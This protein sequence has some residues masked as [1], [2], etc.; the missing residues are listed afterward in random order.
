VGG[1]EVR[2]RFRLHERKGVREYPHQV[3]GE[4]ESWIFP[5]GG[6]F[7]ERVTG[8]NY[9]FYRRKTESRG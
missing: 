1:K 3:S 2:M 5:V 4:V 6:V 8:S 7:D 9:L